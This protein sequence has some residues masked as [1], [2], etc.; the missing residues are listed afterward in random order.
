MI[1]R[2]VLSIIVSLGLA[3]IPASAAAFQAFPTV[4]CGSDAA[5]SAV[6]GSKT[7]QNPISG[8]GG[9]LLNITNIVAYVAGA[10][11]V[12]IIIVSGIR[13]IT[14]GGD[15]N[16]IASAKNT[17]AGA[18]IGLVVIVLARTLI[19]YVIMQL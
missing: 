10:A 7:N 4:D 5:N 11:A 3:A 9:L 2:I 12:I 16:A 6:C 18:L 1:R 17:I 19:T 15:S 13:Y 14:S 8:S